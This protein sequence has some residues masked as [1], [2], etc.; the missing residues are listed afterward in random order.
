[1]KW[2]QPRK[3]VLTL[4]FKKP[5]ARMKEAN[6]TALKPKLAFSFVGAVGGFLRG[7]KYTKF[8]YIRSGLKFPLH[9]T[10]Y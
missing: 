1:M 6:F 5:R 3:W 9:F 4:G 8:S 10:W 7:R 2:R